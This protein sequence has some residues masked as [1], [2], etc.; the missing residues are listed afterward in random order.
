LLQAAIVI[1]KW[2]TGLTT[3]A[4]SA[5]VFSAIVVAIIFFIVKKPEL[6]FITIIANILWAV[7]LVVC[8]I[9]FPSSYN[10]I[11]VLLAVFLILLPLD[12]HKSN[13]SGWLAYAVDKP[14]RVL[15]LV[16]LA[17][18]LIGSFVLYLP[19]SH[20]QSL[21][22]LDTFFTAISAVCVTGLIV[23]DTPVAYTAWGQVVILILIQLGGLG[24]MSVS[25]ILL[26]RL[27]R[28]ISVSHEQVMATITDADKKDIFSSIRLILVFTFLAELVGAILLSA[29]FFRAGDEF[30]YAVWRGLFTS[31][32]A[33]C[34]AGFALQS[35]SLMSYTENSG[36]LMVVSTLIILG[37]IS[38]LSTL[39]IY[40]KKS[41]KSLNAAL[42]L[43]LLVVMGLLVVGTLSTLLFEWN[44]TLSSMTFGDKITNAWFQ[45]VTLRTAGFNSIDQS[46]L[47]TPTYMMSLVWMV[48]G[49]SPGG[50]AGGVKTAVVGLILL[51]FFTQV[52]QKR[53]MT[54]SG[55]VFPID[56]MLKAVSIVTAYGFI[57]SLALITILLTQNIP[58]DY[59]L[60]EVVSALSTVGLS[61]GATNMIDSLGKWILI[62]TMFIGRVGA[63]TIFMMLSR[64]VS[65]D[66]IEYPK[67]QMTLT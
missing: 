32:S 46:L 30:G 47:S 45:S 58:F 2:P 64:E 25:I 15:V 31:I 1:Y 13:V 54:F 8:I 63:V 56:L 35:D 61:M 53:S 39:L 28:R 50:T 60:F 42:K 26:R 48:I 14:A 22:W 16:F 51:N 33:F 34:N 9:V 55:R 7:I 52:N 4:S 20:T 27:G 40:K 65:V 24:I 23:V 57:L 12:K 36:V 10:L 29:M 38:P 3:I 41:Y 67:E 37:G 59:L 43:S 21:S 66:N 17:A 11:Y 18:G 6:R 5:L 62:F 44:E 19:F 49:G